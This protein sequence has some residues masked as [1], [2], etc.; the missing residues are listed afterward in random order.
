MFYKEEKFVVKCSIRIESDFIYLS[1][2]V[3]ISICYMIMVILIFFYY[4]FVSNSII[5]ILIV[6]VIFISSSV[7]VQCPYLHALVRD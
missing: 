5:I 7:I 4:N 1:I 2:P 6:S 3:I